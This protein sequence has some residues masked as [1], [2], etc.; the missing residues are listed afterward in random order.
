MRS[1]AEIEKLVATKPK[2]R[3]L[4]I[5]NGGLNSLPD[6]I[7]SLALH[8]LH[9]FTNAFDA[10]PEQVRR[11]TS[12][13]ELKIESNALE[14]LPP[15]IG[16]LSQ[17]RVLGL[18][19]N[20]LTRLALDGPASLETLN[21]PWNPIEQLKLENL[22]QLRR[23]DLAGTRLQ[24]LPAMG[25]HPELRELLCT[26]C[27]LA[28]FPD[29][30]GCENLEHLTLNG[31]QLRELPTDVAT[32]PELVM[33]HL[34]G[35][36]I[37]QWP[38]RFGDALTSLFIERNKLSE[39]P[40]AVLTAKSLSVLLVGGNPLTALPAA[41]AR[42]PLRFLDL[43]ATKLTK[44][45]D[46]IA[47]MEHLETLLLNHTSLQSWPQFAPPP[48]LKRFSARGTPLSEQTPPAAWR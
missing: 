3:T 38:S 45:P 21:A 5:A 37:E 17:L 31:N 33:L 11:Q 7:D 26:Q 9:I 43:S 32:L 19:R 4:E 40:D 14:E 18:E 1:H 2:T 16:E 28:V 36:Q 44:L 8:R 12:L 22:P 46:W 48:R 34:S 24:E 47:E 13:R 29:L 42:L 15:W 39:L 25:A 27:P 30:D 6:A 23:L 41:L 35:N 10:V 20:K